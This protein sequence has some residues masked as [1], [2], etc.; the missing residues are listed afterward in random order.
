[1]PEGLPLGAQLFER[2]VIELQF[3]GF[4]V[5]H[6]IPPSARWGD[7]ASL[8]RR[9]ARDK[10]ACTFE[11]AT[12]MTLAAAV[13]PRPSKST[14]TKASRSRGVKSPRQ[15]Y[16]R[17]LTSLALAASAGSGIG[18]FPMASAAPAALSCS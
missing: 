12:P 5:P 4:D 10:T 13:G 8:R 7:S 1:M 11:A 17:T 18:P 14:S 2:F 16:T 9:L 6:G 15:R 3:I